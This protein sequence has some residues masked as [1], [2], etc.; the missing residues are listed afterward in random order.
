MPMHSIEINDKV[1]GIMSYELIKTLFLEFYISL[2][3]KI[4]SRFWLSIDFGP[5][6][7][8]IGTQTQN[9]HACMVLGKLGWTKGIASFNQHS[10]ILTASYRYWINKGILTFFPSFPFDPFPFFLTHFI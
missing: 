9:T 3:C 2:Y 4:K 8:R 1:T 5:Y 7:L 6:Q 10:D